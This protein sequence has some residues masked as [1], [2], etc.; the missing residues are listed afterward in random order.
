MQNGKFYAKSSF[1]VD[2]L[3]ERAKEDFNR[4]MG[5]HLATMG[6]LSVRKLPTISVPVSLKNIHR[7]LR[8]IM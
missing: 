3:E 2:F 4:I 7:T 6:D 8:A 5:E 1:S